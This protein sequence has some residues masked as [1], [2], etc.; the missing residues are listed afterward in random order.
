MKLVHFLDTEIGK[1][2]LVY[3]KR[4]RRD[5]CVY[6]NTRILGICTMTSAVGF[7]KSY[8][9]KQSEY[10][11]DYDFRTETFTDG[12]DVKASSGRDVFLNINI[13]E[14]QYI[15]ELTDEEFFGMIAELI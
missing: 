15:Y 7:N 6:Q 10:S 4:S 11:K 1:N 12:V 9:Y 3:T 2:Y 14:T 8:I 13:E 5:R